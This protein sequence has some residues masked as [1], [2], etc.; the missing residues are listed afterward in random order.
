MIV[1]PSFLCI[2]LSQKWGGC[3]TISLDN[4]PPI[5]TYCKLPKICPLRANVLPMHML[6]HHSLT[7]IKVFV[8]HSG[9]ASL[10]G[11]ILYPH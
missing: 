7:I 6:Y 11:V 3:V 5:V 8:A 4:I 1:G 10:H 2:T 9:N